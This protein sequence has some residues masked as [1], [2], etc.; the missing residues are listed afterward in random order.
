MT[1]ATVRVGRIAA[2]VS[3]PAATSRRSG[4]DFWVLLTWAALDAA[5]AVYLRAYGVSAVSSALLVMS[6]VLGAVAV[7]TAR[8]SATGVTGPAVLLL[9]AHIAVL[10]PGPYRQDPP[11][12]PTSPPA[13]PGRGTSRDPR[14]TG[15]HAV[16]TPRWPRPAIR[17]LRRSASPS[18]VAAFAFRVAMT[19]STARRFDVPLIQVEAG[20]ALLG[21][22]D[23]Y[24]THVYDSGYP[25]LPFAAIAAAAGELIGDS[26]PG[27]AF[28]R[29]RH[30]AQ[31][32][33][34]C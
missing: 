13:H 23:P 7:A 14:W 10:I 34:S 5:V 27:R 25:Y 15:R 19:P 8:G 29:G 21:G 16:V 33:S 12:P 17:P 31:W 28:P 3:T 32:R 24:L 30:Y 26:R 20:Q 11:V 4:P 6:I 9:I 1:R 22:S 2:T 18:V